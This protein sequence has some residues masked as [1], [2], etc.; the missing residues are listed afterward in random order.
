VYDPLIPYQDYAN[1][2]FIHA[3]NLFASPDYQALEESM[4]QIAQLFNELAPKTSV[5]FDSKLTQQP[6]LAQLATAHNL[7]LENTSITDNKDDTNEI[8]THWYEQFLKEEGASRKQFEFPPFHNIVL[9][10]SQNKNKKLS[11]DIIDGVYA[12]LQKITETLPELSVSSPYEARFL[13]RKGMYSY[14]TLIR[15]PRKYKYFVP[16]RKAI[17]EINER[18]QVQVR[19]N[20][21]HLF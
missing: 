5:F 15:Y 1:I 18:F 11:H 10:T 2:V 12:E 21:R 16:L 8:S 3:E 9:L 4:R 7:A 14:H 6:L 20:P 13:K 19:L 17:N